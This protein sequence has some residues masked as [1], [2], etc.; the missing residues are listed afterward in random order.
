[1]HS[2]L[3]RLFSNPERLL[4]T[5]IRRLFGTS[6]IPLRLGRVEGRSDLQISYL[7]A[8]FCENH[9]KYASLEH[10]YREECEAAFI[11]GN[12]NNAGDLVRYHFLTMVCDRVEKER[13][14]GDVAELGVYKGNTAFLLADLARRSGRKAYLFDT[15]ESFA[16]RDL[17]AIDRDLKHRRL[18]FLDT[19]LD[20]VKQLVGEASVRYLPGYF[21]ETASA[22]PTNVT[23]AL[24]HLDCDLYAPMRAGLE[25]FYPRLALG[26]FLVIHDYLSLCW[27]GVEKAVDEFFA[28]KPERIVPI[29]DRAGTIV[30]RKA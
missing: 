26:G 23:F 22:V 1:L 25:F 20:A 7:P 16:D 14:H 10:S 3:R 4:R 27:D 2:R 30:I 24:V 5:V 12:A 28:D 15:F 29:P 21:P 11:A 17:V 18:D 6:L 8:R 13:L 19:S 9:Q